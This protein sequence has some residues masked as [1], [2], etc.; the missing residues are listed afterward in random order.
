MLKLLKF[1][2]INYY[3]YLS[4]M[5]I[6]VITFQYIKRTPAN[7]NLSTSVFHLNWFENIQG[8]SKTLDENETT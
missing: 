1:Q 8:D 7:V 4:G 6:H 3:Y 5:S 2:L